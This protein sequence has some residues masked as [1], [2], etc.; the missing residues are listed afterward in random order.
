MQYPCAY[1]NSTSTHTHTYTYTL[2]CTHMLTLG[3]GIGRGGA[4]DRVMHISLQLE[5]SYNVVL[6][7]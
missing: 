4:M 5:K 6:I 7:E 3:G 1:L 2:A